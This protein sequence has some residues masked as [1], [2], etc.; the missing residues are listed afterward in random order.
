MNSEL[1]VAQRD[2]SCIVDITTLSSFPKRLIERIDTSGAV[3]A[4]S[5]LRQSSLCDNSDRTC[6]P[7]TWMARSSKK[8]STAR[9]HRGM[10]FRFSSTAAFF[11]FAR[12]KQPSVA[13]A[14]RCTFE[15]EG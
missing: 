11:V 6:S 15:E 9:T 8:R 3:L 4:T 1:T 12:R 7:F 13:R 10:P 2:S 14:S 5:A